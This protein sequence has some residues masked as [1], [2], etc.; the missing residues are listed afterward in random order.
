MLSQQDNDLI[1]RTGPNTPGGE[2]LRRYWQPV[3]LSE[4]LPQGGRP[5][6][7]KILSEELVLFRD[8]DGRPGLLG[9]HCCHRGADLSYGRVEDGGLR[10]IYH[11]WLYDI[12]GQ[13]I[14]RPGEPRGH[15][16][17]GKIRQLSYPCREAG[18]LIFAYLGA[19]APP[20]LP[21]YEFM[22]AP[23]EGRFVNKVF[24]SCNYQQGNEGNI[25]PI[26]LSFLHRRFRDGDDPSKVRT[27]SGA[28]ATPNTLLGGD[29]APQ[30]EVETT[31]FGV[32]VY[33]LRKQG[34]DD[35]YIRITNFVM[36]NLSAFNGAGGGDRGYSIN[37]HVP[38]D[39]THH[40]KYQISFLRQ[41]VINK[42]E[43]RQQFASELTEDYR[44]IRNKENRYLQDQDEMTSR[45]FAGVGYFF[46]VHDAIAVEGEGP[47]QDRTKENLGYGDKAIITARRL[48]LQAVRD[49]Q[50]GRDPLHVIREP[51]KN[52]F[53]HLQ[54][55]S[56][57]I[58]RSK[59]WRGVWQESAPYKAA[60][61]QETTSKG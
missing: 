13:C 37:W 22:G 17:Q 36:P 5:L 24:H 41:G 20:L 15:E 25:D 4:E 32:R 47:I 35:T 48:L 16:M 60:V 49:V 58:P 14:E 45:T 8:D 61:S 50:E 54:V 29:V 52:R 11:G 42:D 1:T 56:A 40:W 43:M 12:H 23:D 53:P 3:A 21:N 30:V 33:A 46:A 55:M 31:D 28:N 26:H 19:G 34:T 7:V 9:L 10:C 27:V 18:G 57:V 6:P 38:I 51:E 39:D 44:L 2:L 59:E